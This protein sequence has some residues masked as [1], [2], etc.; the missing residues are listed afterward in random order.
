MRRIFLWLSAC[1][2]I[3]LLTLVRVVDPFPVEA[4]RLL[5]LDAYQRLAPR[6]KQDLPVRVVDIDERSLQA[7]GQ[8]PWPR[9]I[10][11]RLTQ[12]LTQLGAAAIVYDVL[13]PEPDRLS[14]SA[15]MAG[16]RQSG[17]V[18]LPDYDQQFAQ[19]LANSPSVL[20]FATGLRDAGATLVGPKGGTAISGMDPTASIAQMPGAIAPIAPLAEAAH[21][22]GAISLNVGD[23][24]NLVRRLPLLWSYKDT[25]YPTLSLEALRLAMGV[26][27]IVIFGETEQDGY[28]Q[29]VRVGDLGVDTTSNGD[30]WMYYREPDPALYVSALDILGEGYAN[31]A[32][33]ITGNIVLIGTSA[34]GLG[35]LRGTPLG[36]TVPGV[37]IH[38]QAI[39]QILS[40]RFLTRSDWLS[41]VEIAAFIVSSLGISAAVL[42]AGPL[43]GLGIG[44]GV[45]GATLW[46]AW[47]MFS[48]QGLLIDASFPLVG[49]FMVFST[50]LFLRFLTTDRDRRQIRRA[51]GH[52]VSPGLLH[53]IEQKAGALK[54]GGET[55][56]LTIMF[57]D[58]R[59]FTT[60]SEKL[61]P[62]QL[63]TMLNTLFG[64]LGEE[65]M[66]EVGT[67]DK[68]IGDAIMAFWNAPLFVPDH[69]A[70]AC[71]AALGMRARLAALNGANA[72]GL[73]NDGTPGSRIVIGMG[74]STGD[75][76]VGNLGLE[77]RFDYSCVGDTVNL[78][79]RVEGACKAVGYDIV[80]SHSTRQA[81]P[82]LAFLESGSIALK[83]KT[84]RQTIHILVGDQALAQSPT[85]VALR[86]Q[87]EAAVK[88]LQAGGAARSEIARCLE[89]AP[90]VDANL[91]TFY[92]RLGERQADFAG[93][94]QVQNAI[95]TPAPASAPDEA[96]LLPPN[97]ASTISA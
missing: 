4:T 32:P 36:D 46:F 75:A 8:W 95:E 37:S 19:A 44:A 28:V 47:H 58:I 34:A 14:P 68:F 57:A 89:L 39:E 5:A 27:T 97:E 43:V 31:S 80:V 13:F 94:E 71:R 82:G 26:S 87:H 9:E 20:G 48:A 60:I 17:G 78:A 40:Q 91:I 7:L 96:K 93:P 92:R 10:L 54:L 85:F 52:Y 53:Q 16:L 23:Q 88:A 77:T 69:A 76:L 49:G 29:G 83:G 35:D 90:A 72:F 59:D 21:G 50:M 70:H 74:I 15:V 2:V 65:I 67:I 45:A 61:T 63:V 3:A 64:A 81:A 55:R 62:E 12:R 6:P 73:G 24:I 33:A 1:G 51:F 84:S 30:L 42:L 25:I 86:R 11:A 66:G 22:L 38:A 56:E 79:S 41:G 18:R